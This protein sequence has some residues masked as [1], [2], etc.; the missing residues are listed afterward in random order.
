MDRPQGRRSSH[1]LRKGIQT[2]WNELVDAYIEQG[3]DSRSK[4]EIERAAKIGSG[5]GALF[6]ACEGENCRNVERTGVK[7]DSCA[8]CKFVSQKTSVTLN[9]LG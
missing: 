4:E 9:N 1:H 3:N 5:N 8:K 7:F 2:D 6:R